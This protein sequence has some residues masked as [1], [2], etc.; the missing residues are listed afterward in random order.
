MRLGEPE[1][2]RLVDLSERYKLT[3]PTLPARASCRS[4]VQ[5]FAHNRHIFAPDRALRVLAPRR[6]AVFN[7]CQYRR[8]DRSPQQCSV[9]VPQSAPRIRQPV[10]T[11]HCRYSSLSSDPRP[12]LN[13]DDHALCLHDRRP[14]ASGYGILGVSVVRPVCALPPSRCRAPPSP[15]IGRS[16]MPWQP[17]HSPPS[18]CRVASVG[19]WP[20]RPARLL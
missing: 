10:S 6:Q 3:K 16:G 8:S 5:P 15:S 19:R 7:L 20:E 14:L 2:H 1:L 11:G 13:P 18:A 12:P 9:Q 17:Y 4:A